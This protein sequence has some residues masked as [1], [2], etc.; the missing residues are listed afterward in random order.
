MYCTFQAL[1][2]SAITTTNVPFCSK[3]EDIGIL[4]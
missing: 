1:E 4:Y 2:S 3:Q